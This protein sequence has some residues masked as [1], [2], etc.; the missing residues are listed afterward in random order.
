[1][2]ETPITAA[3]TIFAILA[4]DDAVI[5]RVAA[6]LWAR[7]GRP[8]AQPD[9]SWTR[10]LLGNSGPE[11]LLRALSESGAIDATSS[12]LTAR[13]LARFIASLL[14]DRSTNLSSEV[15]IPKTVWTLPRS[16]P[17]SS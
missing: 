4:N 3:G 7:V 9:L 14:G 15:N 17:S 5:S 11:I 12:V 13:G 2:P 8:L 6:A 1:M 10:P 16:H